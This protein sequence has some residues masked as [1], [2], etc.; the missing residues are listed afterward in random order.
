MRHCIHEHCKGL[1][2]WEHC[3]V[4]GGKQI[5]EAWAI[6]PCCQYHHR[7]SGLDKTYNQYMALARAT[8]ADL[9]KYPKVDWEQLNIYLCTL[10]D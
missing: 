8:R 3:F 2:E 6:V 9:A 4:Y 7:G 5:N 10:Y 1:P